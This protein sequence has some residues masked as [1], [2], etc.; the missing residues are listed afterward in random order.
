VKKGVKNMYHMDP[1]EDVNDG[2]P[3]P[4]PAWTQH[5]E[6]RGEKQSGFKSIFKDKKPRAVDKTPTPPKQ[7]TLYYR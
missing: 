7:P 1:Y 2:K 5:F 4:P 3:D 6:G